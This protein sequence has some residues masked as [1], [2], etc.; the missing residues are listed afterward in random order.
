MFGSSW[1]RTAVGGRCSR[2]EQPGRLSRAVSGTSRRGP[3]AAARASMASFSIAQASTIRSAH[4]RRSRRLLATRAGAPWAANARARARVSSTARAGCRLGQ[5][6]AGRHRLVGPERLGRQHH[7]HGA[8]GSYPAAPGASCWPPR[9]PCRARRRAGG[10]LPRRRSRPGRSGAGGSPRTRRP[11]R[12]PPPAGAS[13]TR[14]GRRASGSNARP[15]SA[16][17]PGRPMADRSTPA[18]KARPAPVR[19]HTATPSSAG[20]RRQLFGRARRTPGRRRRSASRVA[21]G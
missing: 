5:G 15:S 4:P 9:P 10:S 21:P 7:P 12:S 6:E 8:L 1:H 19:T 13:R 3:P 17:P 16:A 14:P 18:E 11:G 2:R 20:G